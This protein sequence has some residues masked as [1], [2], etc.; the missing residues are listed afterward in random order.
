MAVMFSSS[1]HA[2]IC[3]LMFILNI[4]FKFSKNDEHK[5]NNVMC[6]SIFPG[7]LGGGGEGYLSCRGEERRDI[8]SEILLYM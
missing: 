8:F 7:E 6:G 1:T 3:Q 5:S 2:F 4:G